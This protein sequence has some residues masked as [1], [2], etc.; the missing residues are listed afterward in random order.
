MG[1]GC[2]HPAQEPAV[3][4]QPAARAEE[5]VPVS[6]ARVVRRPVARRVSVV[7]TL[8][9]FERV[10]VTP[11]VEG[12][13]QKLLAEVA[14]RVRPGQ[15]LLEIDPVDF[16]LA[17]EVERRFLEEELARLELDR[18]PGPDFDIEQLPSVESARLRLENAQKQYE[19]ERALLLANAGVQQAYEDAETNLKVAQSTLRQARLAA[20][21]SLAAV[22]HRQ[23]LLAVAEE[24]LRQTRV[25]A[26][27]APASL[28]AGSEVTYV[29]A[30]R[31]VAVG[32]MVRAFPSTPVY[33]LVIDAPLK[34]QA[35]I[36]ERYLAQV[37]VGQS[38]DVQVD[39]YPGE[40]FEGRVVRVYPTI[41]PDSRSFLVE[42]HLP[43]A[44]HRLR[45]GGFAK[46]SVV[47]SEADAA[48][49]IPLEAIVRFAGVTK[50][51][52]VRG[53]KAQEVEVS[54]GVQ[55]DG[56]VEVRGALAPGDQVVV[57]GQ[58]R[59]VDGSPVVIRESVT[60]RSVPG[61]STR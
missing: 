23:A 57:S 19:R 36:P 37:A 20:R 30:R 32:E 10:V 42:A 51:F 3:E 47:V 39:A 38:I 43:N 9:A 49:T 22:R 24:R 46:A 2:A 1:L 17:A 21:A 25:E 28:P 59:L 31:M 4:A 45:P 6:V 56:W 50:V 26:P 18:L 8:A 54:V 44:D 40:R 11:K 15:V 55:Q 52:A 13:V 41:D 33:E 61:R 48:T 60:E 7:G 14:D 53:S 16:Q 12:R 58:S 5:P 35:L 34:L 27:P 29:V